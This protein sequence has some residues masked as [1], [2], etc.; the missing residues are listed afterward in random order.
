MFPFLPLA[1]TAILFFPSA[2]PSLLARSVINEPGKEMIRATAKGDH[3]I[4]TAYR[5]QPPDVKAM[6]LAG[7][8]SLLR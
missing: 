8:L 6:N 5:N 1:A 2:S 7:I 3:Q 4:L